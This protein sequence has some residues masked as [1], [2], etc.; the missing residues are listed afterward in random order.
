MGT[1]K[2]A[3][4]KPFNLK[5]KFNYFLNLEQI[6]DFIAFE[7]K[8]PLNAIKVGEGIN[9]TMVKIVENPFLYA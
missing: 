5:I 3:T 6:V 9:A 4:P 8:Q 2:T 7:Q 1:E